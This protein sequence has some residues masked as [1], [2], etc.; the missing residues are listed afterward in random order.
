MNQMTYHQIDSKV[1][2]AMRL[3]LALMVI[4]IHAIGL[5]S[6]CTIVD[7]NWCQLNGLDIYNFIRVCISKIFC[8]IAVPTFYILSGYYFFY[9]IEANINQ[10]SV[11]HV[12]LKKLKKR[13]FTIFLPYVIWNIIYVVW[14]LKYS[15]IDICASGGSFTPIIQFYHD[16]GGIIKMLWC[17]SSWPRGYED[18]FGIIG[19]NTGPALIPLWFIRDL[20]ITMLLAPVI[21]YGIKRLGLL[22]IG[23]LM[24]LFLSGVS[25]AIPGFSIASV[26]FFSIGGYFTIR[27]GSYSEMLLLNKVRIPIGLISIITLIILTVN[28]GDRSFLMGLLFQLFRVCGSLCFISIFVSFVKQ[29]YEF[30]L[31]TKYSHMTFF[32]FTTHAL[33]GIEIISLVLSSLISIDTIDVISTGTHISLST[34]ETIT[35]ILRY[36]IL[37]IIVM[38]LCLVSYNIFKLLL[39]SRLW[40]LLNGNRN[41]NQ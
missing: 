13:F 35:A 7:V 19:T 22:F 37:P 40:G 21:H 2:T 17:S 5:P 3:P 29:G 24:A 33:W 23:V 9:K 6:S 4:F 27:K 14:T 11:G 25:T 12:Y 34:Y 31:F 15:I 32:V 28:Y 1:S 30:K 18:I 16:N 39:P 10:T 8:Q 41:N 20:M 38:V 26:L 36:I